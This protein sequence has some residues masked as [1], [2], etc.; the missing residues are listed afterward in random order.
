MTGLAANSNHHF[1]R[2][3]MQ[4]AWGLT[5]KDSGDWAYQHYRLM[6]EE[7]VYIVLKERLTGDSFS[8]TKISQ[9][10]KH[11]LQLSQKHEFDPAFILSVIQAE[12]TFDTTVVSPVGAI[13][14][15]QVMPSTA[16]H[17]SKSF[18]IKYRN[19][20]QLEDPF[21]NIS[22]GVRYL[23]QLRDRYNGKLSRFLA[24]YNAGPTKANRLLA[25]NRAQPTRIM[26]YVETIRMNVPEMRSSGYEDLSGQ[27]YIKKI[28]VAIYNTISTQLKIAHQKLFAQQ[29]DEIKVTSGYGV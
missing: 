5:V 20:T 22:F 24:A 6:T 11:I 12:S 8:D 21:I 10:A 25:V 14:L 27:M 4:Q 15:M 17:L 3:Q 29:A 16:K 7:Q 1:Q 23:A 2:Q 28:I 19:Q 18:G 26:H 9:L 13:G